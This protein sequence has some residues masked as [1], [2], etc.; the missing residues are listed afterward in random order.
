MKKYIKF[1][2]FI[3]VFALA[4]ASCTDY[5]ETNPSTS[6]ADSDVFKT[7]QGAQSALY[8][9]Y[10]QMESGNG[11]AGRL[12]D[13]GYVSHQMTVDVT[14]EDLIA[15]GWYY[16]DYS[17][18]GHS[19]A[20]IFKTNCLWNFYYKLI[21]NTNS[22]ITY[23]DDAN[24]S[25]SDKKQIKGQALALR[26]WAYFNLI[27]FFQQTYAVA[28]DMPGV[29]IYTEPTTDKTQGKPRGTVQDVYNQILKDLTEAEELLAGFKRTA[30][31]KNH[32]DRNVAQGILSEVYLTMN[33]WTKAAEYANKARADYPLTS[34]ADYLSGFNN[35]GTRSWMWGIPQTKKQQMDFAS[36]FSMWA[37]WVRTE[38]GAWQYNSFF[39]NDKFVALFNDGDIRKDGNTGTVEVVR[40]C[41]HI[42][43]KQ[44][45][46]SSWKFRDN[47]EFLGSM[48]LMR[49]ET[50]LMNEIEALARGGNETEAKKLLWQLQDMRGATRATSSG[51][52]LIE[53]ILKERRKELYGE[54]F[55]WFDIKR[56]EKG[57]KREGMHQYTNGNVKFKPYSWRL[58]YQ[59]PV[60]EMTNNK[61]LKDG[62]WP[63]GDQNPFDGVFT[64]HK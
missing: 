62:I 1:L 3:G 23:I 26:G 51:S 50:V 37:N 57:L 38:K 18:W 22:I 14:G 25:E 41:I 27:R 59:I 45:Y 35:I 36:P 7:T 64:P 4:L 8:G 20:D 39:L 33:N 44:W 54:G 2:A 40:T 55:A 5:L 32:I 12:D 53:D 9:C 47:D 29:P 43:P 42:A 6:V 13:F 11:G 16:Y 60:N 48:I 58:V 28:K 15:T 63:A 31:T 10:Y 61:S 30:A 49:S 21:N 52:A 24:G 19:R 46:S 34:N 17:Y 56:C